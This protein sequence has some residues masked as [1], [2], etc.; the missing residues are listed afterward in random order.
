M[1]E[2]EIYWLL[3]LDTLSAI[4]ILFAVL[5]GIAIIWFAGWKCVNI[6]D[7]KVKRREKICTIKMPKFL[8]PTAIFL[9]LIFMSTSVLV[10]T[11][12]QMVKMKVIPILVSNKNVDKLK[13]IP[14]KVLN[15][16]GISI[17]K[18]TTTLSESVS[19]KTNLGNGAK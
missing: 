5:S 11:T 2:M 10:P 17:D 15:L 9:F 8:L 6:S 13:Q 1:T 16:L 4:A 19:N 18:L 3:K 14:E 12:M 7:E